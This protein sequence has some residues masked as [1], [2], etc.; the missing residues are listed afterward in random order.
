MYSSDVNWLTFQNS[1]NQISPSPLGIILNSIRIYIQIQ[2][3]IYMISSFY[4]SLLSGVST[5][6]TKFQCP[7]E[8]FNSSLWNVIY[9]YVSL[10]VHAYIWNP[11]F[12]VQW[13]SDYY[14]F[15]V[16]MVD[17]F[18]Q[19]LFSAEMIKVSRACISVDLLTVQSSNDIA[20]TLAAKVRS[21]KCIFW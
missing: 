18:R 14:D 1:D 16:N 10:C 2:I 19:M 3:S 20:L 11:A 21:S 4:L 13:Y 7:R 6:Y 9:T 15:F 8:G 5:K 17:I 12:Y